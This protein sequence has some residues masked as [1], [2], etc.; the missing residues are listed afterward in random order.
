M[1]GSFS[2]DGFLS[3]HVFQ[4]TSMLAVLDFTAGRNN[5]GWMKVG[6]AIRFAQVLN[7]SAEPDP[8][9]PV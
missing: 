1:K 7:L 4:A 9:L 2:E 6:L 8:T 5:R 3:H